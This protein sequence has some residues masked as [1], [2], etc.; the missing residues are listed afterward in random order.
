MDTARHIVAVILLV[1]GLPAILFWF[2]I[3]PFAAFWRRAGARWAYLVAFSAMFAECWVL[4]HYRHVLLGDDLG[5]YWP[6]VALA[7][8]FEILAI[9]VQRRRKKHL[10]AR[11][12]V[13]LPEVDAKQEGGKLLTEGIYGRIRHPRYVEVMLAFIA[14]AL[15]ANYQYL[16]IFLLVAAA[17]IYLLVLIEERELRERFGEAYVEYSRRVPRFVPRSLR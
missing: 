6:L 3:H 17:L 10:T 16:Y 1:A 15:F 11:I 7:A 12:L 14:L 2:L 13:G 4:Y 5:T 8:V 9:L